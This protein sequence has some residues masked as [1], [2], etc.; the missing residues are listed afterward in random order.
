MSAA[1][2][3]NGVLECGVPTSPLVGYNAEAG[4]QPFF[5][6]L[7]YGPNTPPPLGWSFDNPQCFVAT[8]SYV[9]QQDANNNAYT[10]SVQCA[11]SQWFSP[12]GQPA[13]QPLPPPAPQPQP[14]DIENPPDVY[15]GPPG[16]ISE[17]P[18]T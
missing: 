3:P 10:E 4:W 16:G 14:M 17:P 5:I 2:C 11:E 1:N 9:S 12:T 13:A 8:H 6:G 15:L 7:G 18:I